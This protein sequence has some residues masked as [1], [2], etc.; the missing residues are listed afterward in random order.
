MEDLKSNYCV[1]GI[2]LSQTTDLTSACLVVE[3]DEELYVISH[4]WL[5]IEK[6]AEATSR[7]GIP[8]SATD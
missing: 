6:L 2:D 5:P 7:D 4:F 1:A 8:Y 3:K